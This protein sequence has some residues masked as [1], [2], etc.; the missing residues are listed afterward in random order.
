MA[1]QLRYLITAAEQDNVTV[2][3]IPFSAGAYGT[4]TGGFTLIGY[5]DSD[6]LP[7]VYVEYAAGGS[8]VENEND[9]QRFADMFVEVTELALSA[10]DSMDLVR[11]Q[12][13]ALK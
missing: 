9:V 10:D 11:S 13:G 5:A 6:D 3:V 12:A 1:E 8:W 4:M 7:A 2:Q